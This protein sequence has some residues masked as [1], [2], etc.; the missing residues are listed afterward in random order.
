M[1][2]FEIAIFDKLDFYIST[3]CKALNEINRVL[4]KPLYF[5]QYNLIL[6]DKIF[7]KLR[8]NIQNF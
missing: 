5:S 2:D 8:K 4:L 3:T 1:T 6:I 7:K